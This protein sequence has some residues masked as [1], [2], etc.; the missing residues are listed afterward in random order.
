MHGEFLTFQGEKISKSKGGLYTLS[1]L[2]KKQFN[3]LSYRYLNFIT[4]YRDPLNFS[5]ASL[6]SAQD[7]YFRLKNI[8][9]DTKDDRKINRKYLDQFAVAIN[10]DLDMP[11]ALSILW[12]IIRDKKTQGKLRTIKEMDKIF[13]LDLLEKEKIEIPKEIKKLIAEREQAR[14]NKDFQKSDELREKIKSL[15]YLIKDTA[16]GQKIKKI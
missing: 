11:K 12:G 7:A 9:A 5:L 2:Q 14:K 1:E 15:G 6:Q 10:N 8:V 16:E 13:G 3:P 4:H